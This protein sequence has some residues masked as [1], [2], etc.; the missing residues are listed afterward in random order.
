M[1]FKNYKSPGKELIQRR[2]INLIFLLFFGLFIA[3]LLKL[4]NVQILESE[5]YK[6]A[7]KKQYENKVVLSPYRGLIFDRN[8]NVMVSNSYQYSVA[9]DPNMVDDPEMAAGFFSKKFG[10]SSDEYLAKLKA[11]NTSFIY[12]ERRIDDGKT[13]GLDTLNMNG[14]IILKEPKRVYNYGSLASQILGFTNIDNTGQMGIELSMEKELAGKEGFV[15]M[16]RDGKGNNRPSLEFPRKEPEN[17]NNLVLTIDI[18]I[19][20]IAEEE[21]AEGVKKNNADGGKVI[22]MSVKTGEIL[23][24]SSYPSF[25]PNRISTAD[26]IGMKNAVISDIYEPGSTFKIVA[27]A[28]A[29]EEK[30]EDKNSII[31]TESVNEIKGMKISDVHGSSSMT[32]QQVLEQSSNVGFSKIA[33]KIGSEKFYKYARD[34]GFG[35]SSGIELPGENKGLLKKPVE[36]SG[37]TLPYMSIGYEVMVNAMQITDAY[38]AVA[39]NGLMMK[40]FIIK[41]ETASNG[42]TLFENKAT[43]LRQIISE[44]TARTLSSLLTGVVERGTGTD[45]K[46][47]GVKIAGKTGTSQRL[48]NG[49][50]KSNSHNSS[51][52]GYFPADDPKIIVTVIMNNPKSG[53]YYG[54]KVAAPVFKN[55][56]SKILSLSN[57]SSFSAPPEEG[58]STV[59]NVSNDPGRTSADG[60]SAGNIFIPNFVNL[61]LEDA[62]DILFENNLKYEVIENESEINPGSKSKIIESQFPEAN[63][64]VKNSKDLMI[65]L[66]VKDAKITDDRL[67]VV[68]DVKNLSLRKAI[69]LLLSEGLD[70][71]IIGSGKVTG[72]SPDNGNKILP[73]SRV[74]LYCKD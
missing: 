7:A 56:A 45:A 5:K 52:V 14:I 48:V 6:I 9:A 28:S 11:P 42:G 64:N 58:S 57:L 20:R 66:V 41:K 65:K 72:Q 50:Y 47:E 37:F 36:F 29:L 71:E 23:A 63:Q 4:V 31:A 73:K 59:S 32:F 21:L 1:Q 15:I 43:V 13:A 54:G 35:I 26:T 60:N 69:N 46:I 62:K 22:V 8:M 67:V 3:I 34:F 19:Q 27:A 70:V 38:S 49:E 61:K 25:D 33:L 40:P 12:L 2:K 39:N 18:N 74:I 55:I 24:M 17:G 30:I 16:Q 44:N 10:K 53:E 68:P 51:F